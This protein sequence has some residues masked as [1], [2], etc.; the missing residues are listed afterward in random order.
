VVS[1][2]LTVESEIAFCAWRYP[3]D[4]VVELALGRF[5][6]DSMALLSE[7][8]PVGSL[9]VDITGSETG[10]VGAAYFDL[11][12]PVERV[13]SAT[14]I[15]PLGSTILAVFR[16]PGTRRV[17]FAGGDPGRSISVRY[18][19]SIPFDSGIPLDSAEDADPLTD[20][21]YG[22]PIV[23]RFDGGHC[24]D[25]T[26]PDTSLFEDLECCFDRPQA[27]LAVASYWETEL[28]ITS[29]VTAGYYV[30]SGGTGSEA[31]VDGTPII[32]VFDD[33]DQVFDGS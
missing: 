25:S 11:P 12:G 24:L 5:R 7:V 3:F 6:F 23:D 21:W 22:L 20:G 14:T 1:V 26:V 30:I 27:T 29:S 9:L 33:T 32:D 15:D 10:L 19:G 8:I 13:V 28:T 4:V 18:E 16:I 17:V 2:A 31:V